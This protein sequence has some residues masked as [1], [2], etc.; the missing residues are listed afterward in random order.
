MDD[1]RSLLK[2]VE[3]MSGHQIWCGHKLDKHRKNIKCWLTK[4][5]AKDH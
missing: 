3:T 1:W 5:F 4:L 2:F